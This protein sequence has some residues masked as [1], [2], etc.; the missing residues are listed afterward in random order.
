LPAVPVYSGTFVFVFQKTLL[1]RV[2]LFLL[3]ARELS[4]VGLPRWADLVCQ[5]QIAPSATSGSPPSAFARRNPHI[6]MP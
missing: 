3:L 4:L 5:R 6:S 1:R 2:V